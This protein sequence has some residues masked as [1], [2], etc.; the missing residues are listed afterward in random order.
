LTLTL[1]D[2]SAKVCDMQALSAQVP[3]VI[4][5]SLEGASMM[6]SARTIQGSIAINLPKADLAGHT[7]EV[8]LPMPS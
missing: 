5:L 1:E 6:T 2:A 3:A 4:A 7:L 8:E